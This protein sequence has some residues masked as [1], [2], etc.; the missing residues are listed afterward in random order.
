MKRLRVWACRLAG[1]LPD[2]RKDR[3]L[4]DEI[5]GH[6]QLQ[7]DEN[8]RAGMT[9]E[10]ARR[11]AVLK[12]G[13]VESAKEAYRDRRSI[14]FVENVVQDVRFAVRQLAKNPG[15][16]ATAIV[17]LALGMGASLA[18]F[19]F[20][21]SALIQPLPYPNPNS[22]L[23]V[24]E[25]GALFPRSN[26]SYLDY[27]DWK[28][29][30]KVF[31][32]MD[33]Y[34]GS[35]YLL[36]TP[37]GSESLEAARVSDG[38]FRTLGIAPMLGRDFYA[39]EDLPGKPNTVIL[40]YG[41]WQKRFGGK[42]NVIGQTILLSEVPNTIIGVL[43][44]TFEFAPV[45]AAEIWAPLRAAGSCET[46]RSCHNLYGIARLKDGVSIGA[47]SAEMKLIARRLERQYPDSNRGQGASV[48]P[49]SEVIVGDIRPI[50][51]VLLGGAG[52][53]LVIAGVN[54]ASLLLVRSESRRREM[55]VR[56]ALGGSRGS[57]L[58]PV[59]DRRS[60][61]GGR[62]SLAW[63]GLRPLGYATVDETDPGG[64]DGE[65]AVSPGTRFEL[66]R[67]GLRSHA[68]AA[69]GA[70]VLRYSRV[71]VAAGGDAARARGRQPRF[72]GSYVAAV[73]IESGCA[74][75]GDRRGPVSW[76]RI[77]CQEPV[78]SVK[79]RPRIS[80]RSSGDAAYGC[81]R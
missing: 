17:M 42:R 8:V 68:F 79:R 23:G 80:A 39:G 48:E 77:T 37:A 4:S 30:N 64:H 41:A 59:R 7:I 63:L 26:L 18:I 78:S 29:L 52:L 50:L 16:T 57:P 32:S 31:R 71:A 44:R 22:L 6:L 33:V 35:G 81:S 12:L 25:R 60:R 38:F 9:P 14:P 10:K 53:L 49:L 34:T 51:L 43:P 65:P 19:G 27:V 55:A 72:G 58:Q 3:E 1:L 62:W 70:A 47:A 11:Q 36:R 28:R 2:S 45:G 69:C 67:S 74:R 24:N 40:S 20:V 61:F 76:L 75:I 5:E 46:R 15:F 66:A 21:D 56:S 13:G 73:R 54:V